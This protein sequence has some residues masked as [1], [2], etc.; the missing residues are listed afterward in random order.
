MIIFQET[1]TRKES[2]ILKY[3][4]SLTSELDTTVMLA[5]LQGGVVFSNCNIDVHNIRKDTIKY[6]PTRLRSRYRSISLVGTLSEYCAWTLKYID[7]NGELHC[8]PRSLHLQQSPVPEL[9]AGGAVFRALGSPG[10]LTSSVFSKKCTW[11]NSQINTLSFLFFSPSSHLQ[12]NKLQH[13]KVNTKNIDFRI[14]N[15]KQA[16][17]RHKKENKCFLFNLNFL[18][19]TQMSGYKGLDKINEP[20]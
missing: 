20:L 14:W 6:V 2:R 4:C 8:S 11:A 19:K 5:L 3:N 1:G 12:Y 16:G 18:N 7:V 9:G 13:F 10:S 15:T 17:A